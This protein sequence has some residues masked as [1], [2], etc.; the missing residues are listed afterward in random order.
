MEDL[1][2]LVYT[3][4]NLNSSSFV[5][6]M[7]TG[8]TYFQITEAIHC[9]LY[10]QGDTMS[11]SF[12]TM[13]CPE[14][15]DVCLVLARDFMNLLITTPQNQNPESSGRQAEVYNCSGCTGLIK[16]TEK[17]DNGEA[18]TENGTMVPLL[19]EVMNEI[20]GRDIN[21]P[22][23]E[24]LQSDKIDNILDD[25]EQLRVPAQTVLIQQGR[26]S[27]KLYLILSGTFALERNRETVTILSAGEII[28]EMSCFGAVRTLWSV[29][30]LEDSLVVDVTAQEF[31]H[32]LSNSAT[33]LVYIAKLV[34]VR[35]ELL[36]AVKLID[37]ESSMSGTLEDITPAELF[38]VFHLHQKT[39]V[40]KMT[41]P[42]GNAKISFR[43]GGIVNSEYCGRAGKAAIF[44]ILAE[45]KGSYR[46]IPGLSAADRKAGEIGE[47]MMLLMEGVQ[48]EDEKAELAKN[49]A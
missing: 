46:F 15:K 12:N 2:R 35:L 44:A 43:E 36:N 14:G 40:L 17:R 27:L 21:C 47:F 49:G 13:S 30:A 32:L 3:G 20:N 4:Q 16:L 6:T 5:L 24:A 26:P 34:A 8:K 37:T 1:H 42:G 48:Q 45:V 29:R 19:L 11:L 22:F 10:E 25:F 41:L 33:V 39:G 28:G 23:L 7:R 9:P 18:D 38:Q 31:G